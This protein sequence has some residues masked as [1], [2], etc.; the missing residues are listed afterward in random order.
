MPA[1]PR[2]S[3][4]AISAGSVEMVTV[5]VGAAGSHQLKLEELID[6]AECS[7]PF[8]RLHS[9]RRSSVAAHNH[10]MASASKTAGR[11]ASIGHGAPVYYPARHGPTSGS[12]WV[13]F[14]AVHSQNRFFGGLRQGPGP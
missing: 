9:R 1:N 3:C 11:D 8:G 2:R 13:S 12:T 14:A 4:M 6:G 7:R 5:M 10:G